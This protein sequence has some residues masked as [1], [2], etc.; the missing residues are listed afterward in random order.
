MTHL[1]TGP[2]LYICTSKLIVMSRL[3]SR[4]SSREELDG[5]TWKACEII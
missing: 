1:E 4:E 2:V 5:T 3:S